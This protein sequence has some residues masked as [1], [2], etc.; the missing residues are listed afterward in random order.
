VNK[1]HDKPQ[2]EINEQFRRALDILEKSDRSVFITGRAGTGKST[3]LDYFR[4][5]TAKKVAVL[6]P[7]G[8][9]ALNVKG[10]TIHSFFRFKPG[11]TPGRVKRDLI[12][13]GRFGPDGWP[14]LPRTGG[15][16]HRNAPLTVF[17]LLPSA[18]FASS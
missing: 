10:Q 5:T 18:R 4:N 11:I 8:V 15:R 17:G 6:A 14:A 1:K 12:Q 9:A 7:T 3:L 13:G 2:I 16:F